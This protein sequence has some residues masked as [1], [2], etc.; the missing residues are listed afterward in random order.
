M[1]IL[2]DTCA[3]IALAGQSGEFKKSGRKALSAAR[4]AYVSPVSAWEI[5]IKLKANKL[6]LTDPPE[7]WFKAA[8]A[9][10]HLRELPV[11]TQLLCSAA[12]LPLIHRD[13]FDRVII[14]IALDYQIPILTSDRIIPTYPGITTIW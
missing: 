5:A 8:I 13:P 2:L 11:T 9:R 6:N 12:I 4:E 10:Y 7:D 1:N 3:L 14:A